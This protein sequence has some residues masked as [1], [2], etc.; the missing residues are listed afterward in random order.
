MP[1]YEQQL[2]LQRLFQG[3]TNWIQVLYLA[4]MFSVLFW[5]RDSVLN[6][7]LFRMSYV[8]YGVSLV[9]PYVARPLAEMLGQSR[10]SDGQFITYII[11]NAL[12]PSFLAAAII[13]GLG[14]MTP[15]LAPIQPPG[16]PPKHPLD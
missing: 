11:V 10:S 4:G 7:W 2:L 9:A 13:C 3:D 16:P 1:N 6:W 12:G 15:R 5:R 14:S 8:L